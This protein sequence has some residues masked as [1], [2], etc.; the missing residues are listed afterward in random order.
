MD[1]LDMVSNIPRYIKEV[2]TGEKQ[3]YREAFTPVQ[4]REAARYVLDMNKK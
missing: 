1:T 2:T 4:Y 3:A